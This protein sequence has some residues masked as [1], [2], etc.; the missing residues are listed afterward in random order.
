M[1]ISPN[2][3]PRPNRS[4]RGAS[5]SLLAS[6]VIAVVAFLFAACGGN[7]S[8]A[9]ATPVPTAGNQT[10]IDAAGGVVE[11]GAGADLAPDARLVVP[12]GAV[13]SATTFGLSAQPGPEG[14]WEVSEATAT[15]LTAYALEQD[16]AEGLHPI[17]TPFAILAEGEPVGPEFVLDP[18]GVA[19]DEPVALEIPAS[20]VPRG[21][22]EAL[23]VLRE[24]SDGRVDVVSGVEIGSEVVVVRLDHF[25]AVKLVR[26]PINVLSTAV[27]GIDKEAIDHAAQLVGPK[28]LS[29][30]AEVVSA[31]CGRRDRVVF[32]PAEMPS[33]YDL[34]N[35]LAR[36]QGDIGGV[37]FD[38]IDELQRWLKRIREQGLPPV[39]VAEVYEQALDV[40][41]NDAFQALVL[42]HEVLRDDRINKHFIDLV[43]DV[44]GDG[45]DELGARYHLLGTAIYAFWYE[46]RLAHPDEG[47]TSIVASPEMAAAWEERSS[48]VTSTPTRASSSSTSLASGWA[49]TST[50]RLPGREPL[51]GVTAT[52]R[53]ARHASQAQTRPVAAERLP[54]PGLAARA[55]LRTRSRGSSKG[56]AGRW[57]GTKATSN[58]TAFS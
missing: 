57:S 8:G 56:Q 30:G 49:A 13:E 34:L 29:A 58:P 24:S 44:R 2:S 28:A 45:T 3:Q 1:K 6:F 53:A 42:A 5:R 33:Y 32:N 38:Q 7:E 46:H 37:T 22:G 48:P 26:I 27:M 11:V 4:T 25:S 19:F 39:S 31:Q 20:L 10:V 12:A 51:L 14:A 52:T 36:L 55:H 47:V 16:A 50:G 18:D 35:N 9:D 54:A 15:A 41:G 43:T 21:E 23:L 17:W 40:S